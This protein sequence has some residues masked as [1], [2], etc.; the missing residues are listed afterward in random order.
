MDGILVREVA[1]VKDTAQE[2]RAIHEREANARAATN[3]EVLPYPNLWDA[4][5]PSKVDR[6]SSPAQV[7]AS[8]LRFAEL[9]RPRPRKRHQL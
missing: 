1:P 7:H 8:Y 5:D 4:L 2:E 9:C 6:D 3:G